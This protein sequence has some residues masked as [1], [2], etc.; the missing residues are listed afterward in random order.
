MDLDLVDIMK[1]MK[2]FRSDGDLAK[3]FMSLT[4]TTIM[5]ALVFEQLGRDPPPLPKQEPKS[6]GLLA[7]C[8]EEDRFVKE[9]NHE[10]ALAYAKPSLRSGHAILT[11][12]I[13]GNGCVLE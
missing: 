11:A 12:T 8:L 7:L 10:M 6:S 2:A 3:V 1:V 9:H 13:Y 4:N 5:R